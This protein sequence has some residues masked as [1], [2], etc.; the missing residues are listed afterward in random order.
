M[1]IPAESEE[2]AKEIAAEAYNSEEISP[3]NNEEIDATYV[4][5]EEEIEDE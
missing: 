1:W 4:T 3:D 2:H 5:D